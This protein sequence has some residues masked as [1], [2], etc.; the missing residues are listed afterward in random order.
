VLVSTEWLAGHAGDPE[1]VVVDMRWR[2]DGSGERR[3]RAGHIPGAVYLDWSRHIVDPDHPIA[4]MLAPPERFAAA[5][6]ERGIR[7]DSVV[8]AYADQHGSGPFRLWW[9]CRLY[10]HED[11]VRI[12]DGGWRKWVAEGRPVEAAEPPPRPASWT[13]HH[14]PNLVATAEDVK[15]ARERDDVVVLDSRPP[16]QF[17]GEAVWFETGPI[18]AGPDGIART[19]RGPLRAGRVPWAR[20]VPAAELYHPDH[21]FKSPDELRAL[22]EQAGVP[23]V[24]EAITHCGV[25]ISASALLYA[26]HRA[27]IVDV[28]LYDASWEEWG[29]DPSAPIAR[30]D[31]E[32]G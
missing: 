9:A 26:A 15:A 18:A 12:L 24:T 25:G 6:A 5:L 1:V 2:D 32:R 7:D 28:K 3:Y 4:F 29:R 30:G 13:A 23:P 22:F 21:T 31:P 10:G 8:V 16:E 14:G 19:P 27:G 11:Q 17:R 20:N